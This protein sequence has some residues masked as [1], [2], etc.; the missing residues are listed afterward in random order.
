VTAKPPSPQPGGPDYAI[1][2][3]STTILRMEIPAELAE[4]LVLQSG[5]V[6]RGQALTSGLKQHDIRRLVRRR[7][8]AQ[9]HPGIYVD[10]TGSPTWIQRAWAAVLYA[11]PAALAHESALRA[12]D[13]PGHRRG[14][15][16]ETVIHV[17]IDHGRTVTAPADVRVH[18]CRHAN[19]RVLWNLG[20]PRLRYEEAVLDV[21]LDASDDLTSLGILAAAIQARSTTADRLIGCLQSRARV[22]RRD[23]FLAV[24]RDLAEGTCSVLEHEFLV[25]V[26]R[27]H[28]LPR[29]ARQQ[30]ATATMGIVYRDVT[31]A[32]ALVIELDGRLFHD[33]AG[34]RDRDF[35]RDLDAA[36]DALETIRLSWGQVHS[37]SCVTAARL[38]VVLRRR[39]WRGA[40][41]SCGPGCP[42][43]RGTT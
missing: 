42:V 13:G 4:R 30:R 1:G 8:W 28:G 5:V 19:R 31:Y 36:V 10:H 27:P 6:S 23:W 18:R 39:G 35:E 38:A 12:A 11:W 34:Q 9:V 37:R 25:R 15:D 2:C 33:S 40:P 22:P 43:G 26:E 16:R 17:V 21:A 7:E 20:P 3:R 14:E 29:A 32:G 41:V 24:L